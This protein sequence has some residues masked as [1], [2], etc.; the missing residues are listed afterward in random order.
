[1]V[2]SVRMEMELLATLNVDWHL[3]YLYSPLRP[4][5]TYFFRVTWHGDRPVSWPVHNNNSDKNND[6]KNCTVRN[7]V[8]LLLLCCVQNGDEK[9]AECN[10]TYGVLV[11][12]RKA[13]K[14]LK[15]H[16]PTSFAPLVNYVTGSVSVHASSFA[17][18]LHD[19]RASHCL[20]I[21]AILYWN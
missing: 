12:Y 2:N 10:G 20:D 21:L 7:L 14:T 17:Q 4:M 9:N 11:A 13:V 8:L 15:S 18:M 1:M 3:C 6:I 5:L 16:S 19:F